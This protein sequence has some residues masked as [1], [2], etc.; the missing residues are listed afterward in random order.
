MS[1]STRAEIG[2]RGL[3]SQV[4]LT[5]WVDP[6]EVDALLGKA[7]ILVL[8]SFDENLPMSVIEGMGH[9]LAVVAT[10]VGAV[11]DIIKHDE[12]GLLVQTGDVEGLAEAIGRLI[13]DP[14][15]RKRLGVTARAFHRDNLNIDSYLPRL[16]AI[17]R[18]AAEKRQ[19]GSVGVPL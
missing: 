12:T 2:R 3:A 4:T 11:A 6:A 7:D 17:W 13:G 1:K 15:M 14:A 10:P 8:P 9:G 19:T 16:M 5:G 18:S